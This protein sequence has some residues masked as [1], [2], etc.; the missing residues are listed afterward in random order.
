M[1]K[2]A[3]SIVIYSDIHC[4][5]KYSVCP[6]KI[7][8]A[9]GGT[10]EASKAQRALYEAWKDSIKSL[11][12]KPTVLVINGEPI[13]GNNKF[14]KGVGT[15]STDIADQLEGAK[16]L[17]AKI[18]RDNIIFVRGSPYHVDAEGTS[19]E[20]LLAQE[21]QAHKYKSYGG[22]GKT[23][24]ECNIEMYGKHFNFTHH[25][26]FSRWFQYRTTPIA[27][28]MAKMHFEHGRRGF[29]TDVM[30]RSHVHYYVEVRFPHTIG[31]TTPA[32]KFPDGFMYKSGEPTLPDVGCVEIIVESNGKI[33]V[34]PHLTE[35]NFKPMVSHF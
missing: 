5:S 26:G 29:H 31:L 33:I 25:V 9:S 32:W 1:A 13:D 35:V 16:Q 24:Y 23:D 3:K 21:L 22:E 34:E 19:F 20:E 14:S 11:E 30:V 12:Y 18:P 28:E 17:L 4:G 8:L 7:K 10:Y 2:S 15:W 27:S 6:P